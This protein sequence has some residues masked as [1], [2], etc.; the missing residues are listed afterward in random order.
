MKNGKED[1][2]FTCYY[3]NG[4]REEWEMKNGERDGD[5]TYYHADGDRAEGEMKNGEQQHGCNSPYIANGA[6]CSCIPMC[7]CS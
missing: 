4:D 6:S 7:A 2:R 5:S 1:G 3:A